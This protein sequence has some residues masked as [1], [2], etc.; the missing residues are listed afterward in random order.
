MLFVLFFS[1]VPQIKALDFDLLLHPWT[2]C[3]DRSFWL[4]RVYL[5][6]SLQMQHHSMD[7]LFWR[8]FFV[9]FQEEN[10]LKA[11]DFLHTA[12]HIYCANF[13][14][15]INSQIS[16]RGSKHKLMKWLGW[17]FL[18][19]RSCSQLQVTKRK[20]ILEVLPPAWTNNIFVISSACWLVRKQ[21]QSKALLYYF[22]YFYFFILRFL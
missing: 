7:R 17:L 22:I 1:V 13:L 6:L 15:T 20:R 5:T 10:E 14:C 12:P 21:W 16:A 3:F 18:P 9:C 19:D 4:Q 2:F 11:F 8:F